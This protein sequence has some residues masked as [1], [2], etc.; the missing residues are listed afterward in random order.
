MGAP[1]LLIH[2]SLHLLFLLRLRLL[3]LLCLGTGAGVHGQIAGV[4]TEPRTGELRLGVRVGWLRAWRVGGGVG[5]SLV[6][7]VVGCG[8][9]GGLG[10]GVSPVQGGLSDTVAQLWTLSDSLLPDEPLPN[11]DSSGRDREG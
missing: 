11:S 9:G 10:L 3:G 7:M 6:V 8:A 4:I 1:P 2:L 5:W